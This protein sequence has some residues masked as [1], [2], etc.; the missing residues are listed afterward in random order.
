MFH[1]CIKSDLTNVVSCRVDKKPRRNGRS[2]R[3]RVYESPQTFSKCLFKA[4]KTA[5]SYPQIARGAQK[6]KSLSLKFFTPLPTA[7]KNPSFKTSN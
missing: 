3:L 1:G 2:L 4:R 6:A 5:K 7:A